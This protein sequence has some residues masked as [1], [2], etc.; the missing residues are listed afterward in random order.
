MKKIEWL[1]ANKTVMENIPCP[2]SSKNFL[3]QW[4]KQIKKFNNNKIEIIEKN[5]QVYANT[6]VKSCMPFFDSMT[7]GFIQETWCDIY[8]EKNNEEINYFWSLDPQI[9][10]HREFISSEN[11]LK[12]KEFYNL[13]FI[14]KQYWMPKLPKG[15]SMLFIH[16]LNRT[17][18]PFFT[19]SGIIDSDLF[20]ETPDMGGNIPFYI[21]NGFSGIIPA[22]TPMY[23]MIP[24]KREK[25][26]DFG[27]KINTYKNKKIKTFFYDGYKK[28][29][30]QKK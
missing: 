28:M 18:L 15:Y 16:P 23:Q 27:G 25:W 9:I 6:S 8:I 3:P 5:N 11:M 19:L 21:K 26:F 30:W 10:S 13:E 20:Y 12:N 22:G 14:W 7:N 29:Y 17:D 24:I 1:A 4:Y 2:K